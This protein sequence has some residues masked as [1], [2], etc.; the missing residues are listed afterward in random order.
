MV[1]S[2]HSVQST[3]GSAGGRVD[4]LDRGTGDLELDI[5]VPVG[6]HIGVLGHASVARSNGTAAS[7]SWRA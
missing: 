2:S 6:Q 5:G 7:V 4:L 3:P 1:S